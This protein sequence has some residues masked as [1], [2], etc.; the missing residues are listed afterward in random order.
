MTFN[1]GATF[2]ACPEP[3]EGSPVEPRISMRG[4]AIPPARWARIALER[5]LT[6]K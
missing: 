3:V 5:M 2:R 6:V 1:V 4:G